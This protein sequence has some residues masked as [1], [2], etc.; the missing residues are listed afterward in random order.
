MTIA[1]TVVMVGLCAWCATRTDHPISTQNDKGNRTFN[2]FA[3]DHFQRTGEKVEAEF[4]FVYDA[5][6]NDAKRR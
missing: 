4:T 6:H 2:A 1:S 5:S 3:R